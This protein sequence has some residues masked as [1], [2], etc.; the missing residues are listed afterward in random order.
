MWWSDGL[1]IVLVHHLPP[2]LSAG[3]DLDWNHMGQ[4]G[5][6]T[7]LGFGWVTPVLSYVMACI[8]AALYARRKKRSDGK[9]P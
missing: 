8:G 1:L 2:D 3:K 7:E 5:A 4:M 6:M 9:W